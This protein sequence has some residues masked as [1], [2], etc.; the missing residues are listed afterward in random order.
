MSATKPEKAARPRSRPVTKKPPPAEPAPAASITAIAEKPAPVAVPETRPAPPPPQPLPAAPATGLNFELLSQNLA[1]FVEVS[2]K[3]AAAY[4]QPREGSEVKIG[5]SSDVADV[6][7]TLGHVV[8]HWMTDPTRAVEAQTQLS[9]GFLNLWSHTLRRMLGEESSPVA[10][11]DP[12]DK[13]FAGPEWHENPVF[14]FMAQAYKLTTDWANGLVRGADT[15]DAH[16][17]HK[18]EFYL[19][20]IAGAVSPS[21]FVA[22]NPAL[23]AET[24]AQN[25]ENL[26]RGMNLLAEDIEAGQGKLK[27]RQSDNSAFKLGVNLAMTPGKV[28][29]RNDLI[30]LLQYAPSTPQVLKRPL[31][32]VPPWINKFYILDLN[33]DKSFIRWAVAQGMTVFVIS[34]VNP[35]ARHRDKSFEDYMREGILAATDAMELATGEKES[36]IIGYCVGGTLVAVTLAW[37]AAKGDKRIASATLFTTQVDFTDP[38]DLRVF[39]DEE[40][41]AET[42][43]EMAKYGYLEGAK[44]ANAFNMLRPNDLIWSYAVNNY[45][46][47]KAPGA[48]DLLTW[49]SDSTRMP[50]ANH[51][52]YLRNCY[53]HNKLTK[54]EMVVGGVTLDLSKV[55]IPIYNLAAREDHIAPAKSV[56]RGAKSFGGEMN[57]VLA[58]SGHIAG[59]VNP[60]MKPKYQYWL[61]PKPTGT[62]EEWLA[63]AKEHPGSWWPNWLE[64]SKAQAPEMVAARV[65]GEGRLKALCD[66]PGTYVLVK[67]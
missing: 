59:V 40:Q 32:I 28:V 51:S 36:A 7:K 27:M 4:M 50:A 8:E 34:W 30:E 42:E 67:A 45:V 10:P 9:T 13:R 35:D 47:G 58:G 26:V 63:A 37:L 62:F 65:P 33:P 46:K 29:F 2:G 38:G 1:K 15:L 56:F 5:M 31:L 21:N 17:R 25:G 49:N 3:A 14:D 18:A 16:T 24:L 41:I 60:P 22:T 23:L 48:F 54:G 11:P 61:G 20:Q 6:V 12:G 53:L 55:Q 52:F 43:T 19:R 66:A 39:V 44:M 64:W 57:Y